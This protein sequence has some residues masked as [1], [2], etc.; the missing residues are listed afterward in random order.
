M[1][2]VC[3]RLGADGAGASLPLPAGAWYYLWACEL[4]YSRGLRS[5]MLVAK[6]IRP[7]CDFLPSVCRMTRWRIAAKVGASPLFSLTCACEVRMG[8][9]VR[10]QRA[11]GLPLVP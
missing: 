2:P 6:R 10:R 11:A 3:G 7:E 5:R 9:L 1:C 4:R 8:F